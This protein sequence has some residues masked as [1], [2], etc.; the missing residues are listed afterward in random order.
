MTD[1]PITDLRRRMLQDMTN[2]NFADKTKHDYIR[3]VE[4]LA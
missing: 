1:K 4:A 3:H 2:R